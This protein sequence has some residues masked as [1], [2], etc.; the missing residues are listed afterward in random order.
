MTFGDLC[1]MALFTRFLRQAHISILEIYNIFM[2]LIRLR[3]I[4]F[5]ELEQISTDFENYRFSKVSFD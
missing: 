1:K 5:L 2:R 4:A 3:R